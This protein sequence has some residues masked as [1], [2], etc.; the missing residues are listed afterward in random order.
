MF[1]GLEFFELEFVGGKIGSVILLFNW[2]FMVLEFEYILN[3]SVFKVVIYDVKF[4]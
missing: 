2:R 3:D 1:N 4:E